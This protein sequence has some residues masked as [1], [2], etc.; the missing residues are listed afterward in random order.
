MSTKIHALEKD[1]L[2]G[3]IVMVALLLIV[4]IQPILQKMVGIEDSNIIGYIDDLIYFV[5]IYYVSQ[6]LNVL[7]RF[8]HFRTAA[9]LYILFLLLGTISAILAEYT[10]T[11]LQVIFQILLDL[12]F[13]IFILIFYIYEPSWK[14]INLSEKVLKTVLIISIPF[15]ILQVINPALYFEIFND[16]LAGDMFTTSSFQFP[17]LT[18]IFRHPSLTAFFTCI[19]AFYFIYVR[20]S[21][22]YAGLSLIQLLFTFQRQEIITFILL[23]LFVVHF[24]QR[25]V[26]IK[27]LAYAIGA[28]ITLSVIYKGPEIK[29][30]IYSTMEDMNVADIEHS[31]EPRVIIYW[32]GLK[33][34]EEYFPL[35]VGFGNY[36]GFAAVKYDAVLYYI[37]KFDELYWFKE[38][39]F[40]TDTY[41]PHLYTEAGFVGFIFYMFCGISI[42]KLFISTIHV[43][44]CKGA[45]I[46]L[47]LFIFLVGLTSPVLNNPYSLCLIGYV[48]SIVRKTSNQE[49]IGGKLLPIQYKDRIPAP[50]E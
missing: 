40:L 27:Y 31:Q 47:F 1:F 22:L 7:L 25:R 20:R 28:V 18:G 50:L 21:N 37:L 30:Y 44:E 38:E 11:F 48:L 36:G 26:K 49:I 45:V 13:I 9:V 2:R 3:N 4:F 42:I 43:K 17:R 23:L 35:G 6:N 16:E 5:F 34:A 32:H 14:N 12:K 10:R 46:F 33:L 19:S 24:Y 15:C 29:S 39:N 41:Y 8:R